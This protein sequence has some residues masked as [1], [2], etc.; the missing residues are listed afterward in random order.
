LKAK[1]C[2]PEP[3]KP[4]LEQMCGLQSLSA[5]T[6]AVFKLVEQ[7]AAAELTAAS[8]MVQNSNAARLVCE[9]RRRRTGGQ[10]SH[11]GNRTGSF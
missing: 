8:Q 2:A 9:I 1:V 10:Q 11:G 3:L 4:A 5:Q 6:F 7:Q